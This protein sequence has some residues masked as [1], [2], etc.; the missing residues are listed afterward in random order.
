MQW[1]FTIIKRTTT[2]LLRYFSYLRVYQYILWN[3]FK[4][5]HTYKK[6]QTFNSLKMSV[7]LVLL[8]NSNNGSFDVENTNQ[9]KDPALFIWYL[10]E[11]R[12][13]KLEARQ[14]RKWRRDL[15]ITTIATSGYAI[16]T[17]SFCSLLIL[18][19]GVALFVFVNPS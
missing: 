9:V 14:L 6:N 12:T 18:L 19:L 5:T 4:V 3:K 2:I 15:K 1:S 16:R 13:W 10:S 17:I 11:I 7:S 8:F